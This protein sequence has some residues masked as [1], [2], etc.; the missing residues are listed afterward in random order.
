MKLGARIF[1]T[2]IAIVFA[3][4]IADVLSLPNPVFAGIAAIFAIQP[5]IYRSY[6][7][8]VEQ[9]QGN[10]IGAITAIIFVLVFGHQIVTVGFAAVIIILIMLKL[11]LEKSVS[12]A[13]VTM[14]AIMEIKGDAFLSFATLRLVTIVIGVLS[15]F[16]V[17][18]LFMPPK[19]E[20]KL[21]QA[22]HQSQDEIIRW[23]RLA[24]RQASEHIATK[25]SLDKLKERLTNVNQ[26]YTLFKEER[27]YFKRNTMA[28]ARKLV[29]YRQMIAASK[30]SYEVLARLHKFENELLNLPEHFRMMIQERLDSLLTYHEQIHLKFVGKLKSGKLTESLNE[31]YIQRQEVM[32]IFAKEIAITK[33]EEEFS[34][35]HLLHVLSA[36]L[37]YEEQLEHL[38]RLIISNSRR[39]GHELSKELQNEIF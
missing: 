4:F 36:L 1:K 38:D 19:Y 9:I 32:D 39:H 24:G 8:I 20:T 25:K 30:S 5:T 35:Y 10:L 18:L 33:E 17:N 26:L 27:S 23:I 3:L 22:I 34:A 21:F 7:T 37:N 11:G 2:G 14:I 29:I 28:K 12:L 15:A 16:I 6:L 13:L 31:E